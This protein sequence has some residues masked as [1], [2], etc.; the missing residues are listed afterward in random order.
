LIQQFF[1][2]AGRRPQTAKRL[3]TKKLRVIKT[4]QKAKTKFRI[5][6]EPSVKVR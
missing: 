5:Q 6:K 2:N 1:K 4:E 3:I